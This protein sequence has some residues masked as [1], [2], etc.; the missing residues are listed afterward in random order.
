MPS[1]IKNVTADRLRVTWLAPNVTAWIASALA[2]RVELCDDELVPPPSL[3]ARAA[4]LA[5]GD[6]PLEQVLTSPLWVVSDG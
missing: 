1:G 2:G 6:E 3:A 5:L 4:V